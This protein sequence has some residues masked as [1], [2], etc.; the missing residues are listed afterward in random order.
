M[1]NPNWNVDDVL[2]FELELYRRKFGTNFYFYIS[3]LKHIY[4]KKYFDLSE[5]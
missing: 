2:F 5:E 1:W 3:A 4:G